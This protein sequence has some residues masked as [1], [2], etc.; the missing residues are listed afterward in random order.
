MPV[1][2]DE[3]TLEK[4]ASISG[5]KYFRATNTDSLAGIYAEIDQLEK[6]KVEAQHFVDYRELA[7]QSYAAGSMTL[8]P[9]LLIAFALLAVRLLLQQ[10]WLRE[11]A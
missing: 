7:V 4:V 3:A 6:T 9:L 5:G 11:L 8:P 1:N 10:T 2:I